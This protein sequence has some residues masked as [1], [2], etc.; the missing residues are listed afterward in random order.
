MDPDPF[1]RSPPAAQ[2]WAVSTASPP[3]QPWL[4][5]VWRRMGAWGSTPSLEVVLRVG[6]QR[7]QRGFVPEAAQQAQLSS[8][9]EPSVSQGRAPA[10]RKEAWPHG[11]PCPHQQ[12]QV[13]LRPLLPP[14]QGSLS[15]GAVRLWPEVGRDGAGG[16]TSRLLPA[17]PWGHVHPPART[18]PHWSLSHQP[19]ACVAHLGLQLQPQ[20]VRASSALGWTHLG[21]LLPH[22]CAW[23]SG[24]PQYPDLASKASLSGGPPAGCGLC[25]EVPWAAYPLAPLPSP[26]EGSCHLQLLGPAL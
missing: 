23:A 4:C 3:P 2:P 22:S 9:K 21:H 18:H 26:P 5:L 24:A 16:A 15:S 1:I 25:A 6:A 14:S 19:C 10:W 7:G 13:A 8:D 12:A 11:T 20:P 17:L